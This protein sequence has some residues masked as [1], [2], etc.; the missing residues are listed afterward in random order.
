MENLNEVP[1]AG[2]SREF[3]SPMPKNNAKKHH[4]KIVK[5]SLENGLMIVE[6]DIKRLVASSTIHITNMS[7]YFAKQV[8]LRE[9]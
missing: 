2:T 8:N 7:Y 4:G 9:I 5:V 1:S 6:K 3:S